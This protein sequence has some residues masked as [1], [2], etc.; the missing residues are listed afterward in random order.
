MRV[1]PLKVK[2]MIES[3]P[4]DCWANPLLGPSDVGK[5][6]PQ[7]NAAPR[8]VVV[9]IIIIIIII[10]IVIIIIINMIAILI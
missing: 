9:V 1:P 4:S 3:S 5:E 2:I 8:P 10:I 7:R 6:R